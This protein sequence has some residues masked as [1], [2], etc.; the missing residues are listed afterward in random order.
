M[1]RPGNL[2]GKNIDQFRVDE[3]IGQGAMGIVYKA[4]DNIL[5]R[6]VA[7]KLIPKGLGASTPSL[8]EARK[9]LIQEAQ[10]A[11]RLSHPNIVTIYCYGETDE[12]QYICMEYIV[13][14]TLGEIL[15]EQKALPVEEAIGVIE[16][17]LLA[18][19]AANQEQIVHRD[20]KPSNIM[21]LPDKR[22]KVM[23][24]GI[25]KVPSLNLTTTGT[26]LGTPYY[27]SPEQITGQKVDIQ[28]DIFSVGS[29]FYQILTGVKPF[30]GDTTVALAYKIVQVEPVPPRIL[31]TDIPPTV[32]K[33]I[34]KAMAKSPSLRYTTPKQMLEDL[35]AFMDKETK[36]QKRNADS[37]IVRDFDT[38]IK[39]RPSI[40]DSKAS[41]KEKWEKPNVSEKRIEAKQEQA[42]KK[43]E[44]IFPTSPTEI[45]IPLPLN[46]DL[47]DSSPEQRKGG[48]TAFKTFSITI[49]LLLVLIVAIVLGV[50]FLRNSPSAKLSPGS[51]VI[52]EK[53]E[54]QPGPQA[55]I[56]SKKTSKLNPQNTTLEET[57]LKL[58]IAEAERAKAE[59]EFARSRTEADLAKQRTA[60][61][62]VE[63]KDAVP[64]T[65][66]RVPTA[67]A[68]KSLTTPTPSSAPLKAAS[69]IN[70][71]AEKPALPPAAEATKSPAT[72]PIPSSNMP[73]TVTANAPKA[74][75]TNTPLAEKPSLPPTGPAAVVSTAKPQIN[76]PP[77]APLLTD[78]SRGIARLS[79][80]TFEE[81]PAI[82]NAIIP[83]RVLNGEIV[84]E[85]GIP[86]KPGYLLISGRPSTKGHLVLIGT[87]VSVAI[88]SRGKQG[89]VRYEGT[90]S[91]GRYDLTGFQGKRRCTMT[92][93]IDRQP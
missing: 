78:S 67:E 93:R 59:A 79:C 31:K 26:I 23:D 87:V 58:Q 65:P 57:K 2:I 41:E 22:A 32:E 92:I 15:T 28:S 85:K 84:V 48:G 11:G 1:M 69:T 53:G 37:V 55:Q 14:K 7:L 12:F 74:A 77:V 63:R 52:D 56:S 44:P 17:I 62:R 6:T 35:H 82:S 36:G 83:V 20:I 80:E 5:R 89:Q 70:P 8:F 90:D 68:A 73:D 50:R 38:T 27:M 61:L 60:P 88:R 49:G 81:Q 76:A 47:P 43:T 30:E 24:F 72:T 33:I 34:E 51:A 39:S 91:D 40:P 42:N 18:L 3:F 71:L 10:A 21:I 29:V 75:S 46:P 19:D 13:G 16:Q 9:R 45:A 86:G 54:S 64:V 66:P 4:F 25:A